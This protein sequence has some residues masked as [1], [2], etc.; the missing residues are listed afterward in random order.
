LA[1]MEA[2]RI[3]SLGYV[4]NVSDLIVQ[5]C[6][7]P[8]TKTRTFNAAD[9]LCSCRQVAESM[10]KVNPKARITLKDG[11][12]PDEA[13]WGGAPSEPLLDT[14][15]IKTELGWKPKYSLEE[16]LRKIFNHFRQQEGLPLL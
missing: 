13:T 1:T 14:T 3:R 16:A 8:A 5:T 4:E 9:Y 15:G 12:S 7:V 6:E 10:G 2:D 11:V